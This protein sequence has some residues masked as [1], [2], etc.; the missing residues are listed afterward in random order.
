MDEEKSISERE[1][2]LQEK[3]ARLERK[4]EGCQAQIG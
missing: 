3:I 4:L 1:R 2:A